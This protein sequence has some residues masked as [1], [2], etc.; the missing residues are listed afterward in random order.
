MT[1]F[2]KRAAK[3][4]SD[5]VYYAA[6]RERLRAQ[7]AEYNADNREKIRAYHAAY[8]VEN[9]EKI[10]VTHADYAASNRE[11]HRAYDAAYYRVHRDKI[12]ARVAAYRAAN[13][14][15]ARACQAVSYAATP[16]RARAYHA[17]YMRNRHK[18]DPRF[19]LLCV[20]RSRLR[21]AL[22][23]KLKAAKTLELLGINLREFQIYLRS[24]FRDGMTFENHGSVW[25]LDHV[26]PIAAFDMSDPEQQ[27]VCFRWDNL[28]PLLVH[29]NLSKGSKYAN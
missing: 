14:E 1:D 13:P 26:K 7:Q 27:K 6:N 20:L 9:R 29:E 28:Q 12:L 15:K 18:T 2:E 4:V 5:A 25:H 8:Y 16:E 24:Q 22:K 11:A 17:R 21:K 23:G 10:R 19:K 3:R